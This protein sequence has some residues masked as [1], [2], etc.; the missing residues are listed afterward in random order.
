MWC[1]DVR[2]GRGSARR[3]TEV[4]ARAAGPASSSLTPQEASASQCLQLP[5]LHGWQ[6]KFLPFPFPPLVL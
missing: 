3:Q 6:L 1:S 2:R 5:H 4:P